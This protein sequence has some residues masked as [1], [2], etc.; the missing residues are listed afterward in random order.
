[1]QAFLVSVTRHHPR[2]EAFVDY[3]KP[4]V[5]ELGSIADNTRTTPGGNEK[6]GGATWHYDKF[7]EMSGGSDADWPGCGSK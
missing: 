6:G 3:E 4:F 1:M 2:E 7:C 5:K